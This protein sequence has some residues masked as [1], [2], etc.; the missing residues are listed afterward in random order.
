MH[1]AAVVQRVGARVALAD[2]V[3]AGAVDMHMDGCDELRERREL[4]DERASLDRKSV[5]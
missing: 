2:L 3:A 4:L 5:V 1:E